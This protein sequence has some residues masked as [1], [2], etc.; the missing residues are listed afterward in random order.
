MLP[1]RSRYPSSGSRGRGPRLCSRPTTAE[2]QS[3]EAG[4]G[5]SASR[6]APCARAGHLVPRRG[7]RSRETL[8]H[9]LAAGGWVANRHP[10][11]I[12]LCAV[13]AA[14]VT[15]GSDPLVA[16]GRGQLGGVSRRGVARSSAVFY[17]DEL[18]G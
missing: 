12:V 7:F 17:S 16:G 13:M 2:K 15:A 6:S 4:P 5:R 14:P 11:G 10:V 9:A 1:C 8:A 18:R 3:G